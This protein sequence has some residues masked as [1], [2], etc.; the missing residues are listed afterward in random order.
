M[1]YA[2]TKIDSVIF[3]RMEPGWIFK[4]AEIADREGDKME[5]ATGLEDK[6]NHC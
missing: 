5:D 4:S 6:K 1:A 2:N 3:S